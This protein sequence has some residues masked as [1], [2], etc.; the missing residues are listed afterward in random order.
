MLVG[1]SYVANDSVERIQHVITSGVVP[2]LV[3]LI[4]TDDTSLVVSV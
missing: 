4:G 2:R 1:H 3:Q